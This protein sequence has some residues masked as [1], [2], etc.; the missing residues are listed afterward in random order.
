MIDIKETLLDL[1]YLAFD[2]RIL[3]LLCNMV[4]NTKQGTYIYGISSSS[5]KCLHQHIIF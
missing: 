5:E 2:R 3:S 1:L 4:E